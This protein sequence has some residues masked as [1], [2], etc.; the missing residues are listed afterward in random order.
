MAGDAPGELSSESFQ[1]VYLEAGDWLWGTVEGA[2]NEKATLSQILVDAAIGMIPFVGDVTGVR[3]LLAVVI[4]L[5]TDPR[6]R[7]E[8]T[9]WVLLV[10]L[11]FALILVV[12]G[13]IKGVG[14]LLLKTMG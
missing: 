7:E 3:D 11:S 2:F 12:G 8:K 4:G 6:K 5:S 1:S 14:R 10:V 9:Q 13:V